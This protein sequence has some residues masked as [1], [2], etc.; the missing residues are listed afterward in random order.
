MPQRSDRLPCWGELVPPKEKLILSCG[1]VLHVGTWG[2]EGWPCLVNAETRRQDFTEE[3]TVTLP[4]SLCCLCRD[5][6]SESRGGA[7]LWNRAD[8][9]QS[10]SA[11]H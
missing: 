5:L 1:Q 11:V 7:Q 2:G 3:E 8:V 10:Q 4:Q 6:A 9:D